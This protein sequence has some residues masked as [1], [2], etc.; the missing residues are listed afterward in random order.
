MITLLAVTSCCPRIRRYAHL[1][2]LAYSKDLSA[3]PST[4]L[5][6]IFPQTHLLRGFAKV[7]LQ[8]NSLRRFTLQ[9]DSHLPRSLILIS[10]VEEG[11]LT[12]LVK[13]NKLCGCLCVELVHLYC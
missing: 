10:P 6:T 4:T 5:A 3:F 12:R 8:R 2:S 1:H 11:L 13:L 9:T 7:I